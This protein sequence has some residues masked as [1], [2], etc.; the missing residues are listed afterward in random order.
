MKKPMLIAGLFQ[1]AVAFVLTAPAVAQQSQY[2]IDIPFPFH[3]G[4]QALPAGEYSIEIV[5]TG[6]VKIQG[7]NQTATIGAFRRNRPQ[8]GPQDAEL[9]FHRYGQRY[10]LSQV[11]FFGQ[12]QG[13]EL[14]V[15]KGELE[16]AKQVSKA[17][18]VLRAAK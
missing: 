8:V 12:D 3:V 15:T 5:A 11:W 10:F 6:A 13:Y 9:D 2:N 17:E 18:T 16:Y 7:V 14:S 4:V 1:F